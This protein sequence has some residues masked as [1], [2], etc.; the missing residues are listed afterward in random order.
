MLP[1]ASRWRLLGAVRPSAVNKSIYYDMSLFED[2]CSSYNPDFA[3]RAPIL[4]NLL[5]ASA[6]LRLSWAADCN[7]GQ[8]RQEGDPSGQQ[9]VNELTA[10]NNIEG[11]CSG[12]WRLGDV[13]QLENTYNYWGKSTR[14][15][16]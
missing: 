13:E 9:I 4:R 11:V 6:H 10:N 7:V 12:T 14:Q 16:C 3:M 5:L 1:Q 8:P 15:A 2:D